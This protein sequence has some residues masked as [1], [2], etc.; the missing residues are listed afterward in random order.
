MSK[1]FG[2][3]SKLAERAELNANA[4]C[5][6]VVAKSNREVKG[7]PGQELQLKPTR[8]IAKYDRY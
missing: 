4:L 2:S 3:V 7:L 8:Q 1:A 6:T 5:R